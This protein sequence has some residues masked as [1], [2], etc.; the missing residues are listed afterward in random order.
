MA[1]L[2]DFTI[3]QGAN[4]TITVP[5]IIVTAK[6][7]DSQNQGIVIADHSAG[8]EVWQALRDLTGAQKRAV[9]KALIMR[10]IQIRSGLDDGLNE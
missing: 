5:R 6:V 10:L 7:V 8:F 9:M 3:T 1:D 2:L 4:I